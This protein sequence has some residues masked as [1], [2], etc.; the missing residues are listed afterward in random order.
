M[1]YNS[2]TTPTNLTQPVTVATTNVTDT[3]CDVFFVYGTL[4]DTDILNTV[5]NR[6][7]CESQMQFASVSGFQKYT[8]PGDSFP[9][10]IQSANETVEGA[11]LFNLSEQ[12]LQRM[13]FYEGD[14]YGF[15]QIE[16]MLADGTK[17]NA[18]YNKAAG[19]GI[20]S[21]VLWTL[22]HWQQHEKPAFL[23]FVER[24]MA[25]FGTMS[26]DEADVVWR[27]MVDDR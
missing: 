27:N 10:L 4:L 2:S 11:L 16:A 12:D 8:Y 24:Y 25:L 26:V 13:D 3:N 15:G 9:I 5:L 6:D 20:N 14:E 19:N 17:V 1:Q 21:D 18:L 22:E 7:L 23:G